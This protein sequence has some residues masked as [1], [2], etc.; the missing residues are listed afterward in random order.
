MI[1]LFATY[2]I[3]F[4]LS[5]VIMHKYKKELDIDD[6]DPPHDSYYDDYDSNAIAY[7]SFSFVWPLFWLFKGIFVGWSLLINL[8]KKIE[9]KIGKSR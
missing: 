5:L 1:V 3:G 9:S 6:Y 8:S 7:V 2:T 4:F